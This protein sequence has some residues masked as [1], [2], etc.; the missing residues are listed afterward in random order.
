MYKKNGRRAI[1]PLVI[2]ALICFMIGT[3][4]LAHAANA[5]PPVALLPLNQLAVPEPPNIYDFVKNKAAAVRLGKALFW[6]MQVGSD[7]ITACATCHFAAGTD[8][9]VKNTLNPG[10]N[11]GDSIFNIKGLN[12]TLVN[13]D[14]PFHERQAPVDF[15]ASPQLRDANDIV[16]SQGVRLNQFVS[17][18]S[19][20]A[21]EVGSFLGDPIFNLEG[22]NIRQV[23]GRNT[24]SVI[25]AVFNFTNFWDGRASAFFNGS[26]PFGPL[27]LNAGIWVESN[28]SLVKQPVSLDFASLAS[29]ATGPPLSD[30]EMS[31]RGRTFPHLGKKLLGLTPL[32]KQIVLPDDSEL[33]NLSKATLQP[34]GTITG[35]KG[36]NTSYSQMIR[37]AFQTYLWNSAKTQGGFTQMESN[38][39]L[40]WGLAIQL[41]EA[42]LVSDDTP[43]DRFL[44]G[45]SNALTL[46][47]QDGFNLFFGAGRCDLCHGATELTNAS[48]RASRYITNADHGLLELMPVASGQQ[49]IYD[50]GFNNTAVRPTTEDVCRA[51]LSPFDN[52]ITN[53][54]LPL[55]FSDLAEL[56][57]QNKLPFS[58]PV[59]IAGLP[60][61]FPVANGG[62]F[63]VPGL[64]NVELTA[65]FM[66]NGSMLTLEQ[67]VDFYAR[68]GNFP[69]DNKAN[70]DINIIELP[71][72]QG[73]PAAKAAL[74]AFMKSMTDERVRNDEAPFDHPEL[75]IPNGD[76]AD[77][78]DLIHLPA[79]DLLGYAPPQLLSITPDQTSPV[80]AGTAVNFTAQSD[81]TSYQYRFKLYNGTSW[82]TVQEYSKANVWTMPA[83]TPAGN[84]TVKVD[85]RKSISIDSDA[86]VSVDFQLGTGQA[87]GVTITPSTPSPHTAGSQVTFTAAGQGGGGSNYD[88][89]FLFY[90]G[91]S[92]SLVQDYGNGSSW[93]MPASTPAGSYVI[94][95]DVRTTPSVDRDAVGYLS[96]DVIAT[97]QATGVTITP[98]NPTPHPLGTAVDFTAAGQGASNYDYR[99]NLYNGTS[100]TM[101]Q[102]YGNGA[103]WTMPASTPAGTYV[104][105]VD[106]RTSTAVDRD[107]VGYLTYEVTAGPATGATITPSAPAPHTQGT[108][109]DFTA[110]GQGSAN[111]DY[112][113]W[114]FNGTTWSLVQNYG[115]GATWT[116]PAATPIGAYVVGVDVRTT[117][118]VDRDTVAYLNYEVTAGPA[119]GV[120]ITP[121]QPTPHTGGTSV[122]FVA[123]GQGSANY[124]Y[125]FWLFNGTT[126]SLVQDYGN[127]TTWTMPAATPVG[128]YAIAVDV[129][130][131]ALVDRDAVNY[132]SYTIQ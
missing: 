111:Y 22:N 106:V 87:T 24:P 97:A 98:N 103:I 19:G 28:G 120:T 80:V 72:L 29:Q 74:V 56:Q 50:N 8:N 89:R 38:F 15:K 117:S 83:S 81:S 92:W 51:A 34:D 91:T 124:D 102:N 101:V 45:D 132:S 118:T 41:Y 127:G 112:R 26:S 96:Y 37:D 108:A 13:S 39:P 78:T 3:R 16:G 18:V 95:V 23:T 75:F 55:S 61:T 65:P 105:A 130:T 64:R 9:R 115:N 35:P 58:T 17:L 107:T 10:T 121:S 122:D 128:N 116:M 88:Y 86:N 46:Q 43:F 44:G 109:V 68:G 62:A 119:T 79:T 129:R 7:G 63:K 82:Q 77:D 6:D 66:H 33:G 30:V 36:L 27:D 48:V 99:F 40:F 70:L 104:I 25:N 21:E 76:S 114:L 12:Q 60:A 47:Q 31:F 1:S 126:W 131:S 57:A 2:L 125:R 32:G 49:I 113:F 59:L 93:T 20:Q 100:W 5:I 84:Y 69:T 71:A 42:T 67:V 90:D 52:P 53:T 123:S 11:A 73:D 14:F 54:K 94:A 110:A 85:I 4:G